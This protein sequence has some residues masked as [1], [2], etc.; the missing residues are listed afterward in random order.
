MA[1]KVSNHYDRLGWQFASKELS[2]R[3]KKETWVPSSI[4]VNDMYGSAKDGHVQ[5]EFIDPS[6]IARA[7]A[8][9]SSYNSSLIVSGAEGSL[10]CILKREWSNRHSKHEG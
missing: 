4:F 5:R 10:D 2:G 9:S 7:P 3:R 1:N 8:G 6:G